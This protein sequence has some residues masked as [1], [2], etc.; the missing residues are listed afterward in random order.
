M[1]MLAALNMDNKPFLCMPNDGIVGLGLQSLAVGPTSSFLG[2]LFEGSTG[3]LPQFGIA[4][5]GLR[6]ELHLGG[7]NSARLA[8]PLRWFSVDHPE[9]GYWQ[10]A[11][12]GVRVAT[13]QWIR[14][15]RVAT[16]SS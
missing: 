15:T 4:L 8:A 6:G 12:Q 2:R 5:A 14:A 10:V 7:H 11:I 13:S 9:Q 1:A 16:G 3:V